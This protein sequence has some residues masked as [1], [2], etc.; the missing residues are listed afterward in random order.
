MEILVFIGTS[1]VIGKLHSQYFKNPTLKKI[2]SMSLLKLLLYILFW[3]CF[4]F[5]LLCSFAIK[6][7]FGSKRANDSK[8]RPHTKKNI[9]LPQSV[10]SEVVKYCISEKNIN[11]QKVEALLEHHKRLENDTQDDIERVYVTTDDYEAFRPL[12]L[13]VQWHQQ[14]QVHLRILKEEVLKNEFFNLIEI[15]NYGIFKDYGRI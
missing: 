5:Y 3:P 6:H 15:S 14:F 10:Y 4:I 9:E 8:T 2:R 11:I 1:Y 13:K 12:S 7:F